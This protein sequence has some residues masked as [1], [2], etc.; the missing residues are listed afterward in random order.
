[1]LEE[2]KSHYEPNLSV[3]RNTG[4]LFDTQIPA[5]IHLKVSQKL[6]LNFN[7]C[8]HMSISPQD[9][10]LYFSCQPSKTKTLQKDLGVVISD[11][12]KW[13]EHSKKANTKERYGALCGQE[14]LTNVIFYS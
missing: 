5:S 7:M 11:D 13:Y 10:L 4:S 1:M 12:L 8:S 3:S 6:P 14:K 2:D 9:N